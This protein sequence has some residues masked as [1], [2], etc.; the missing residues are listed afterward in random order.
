MRR[1]AEVDMVVVTISV[2]VEYLV[3]ATLDRMS[4][5]AR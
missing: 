5:M 3:G 2:V 4:M 1:L